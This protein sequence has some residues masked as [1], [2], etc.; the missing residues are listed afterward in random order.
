MRDTLQD[1]VLPHYAV[2]TTGVWGTDW[3]GLPLASPLSS[4]SGAAPA[5]TSSGGP[6]QCYDLKLLSQYSS[7]FLRMAASGKRPWPAA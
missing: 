1:F 7:I 5:P 6:L 4:R 2:F 3:T